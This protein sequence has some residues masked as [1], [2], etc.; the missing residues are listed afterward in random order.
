[1]IKAVGRSN[2]KIILRHFLEVEAQCHE[3]AC[4]CTGIQIPIATK[5]QLLFDRQ[6]VLMRRDEQRRMS[7]GE[8][9]ISVC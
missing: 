6:E 2:G 5:L 8:R 7:A 1:M 3:S 9:V 4:R